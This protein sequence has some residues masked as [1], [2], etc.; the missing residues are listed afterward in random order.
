M[1]IG[2]LR[3]SDAPSEIVN[4]VVVVDDVHRRSI[5]LESLGDDCLILSNL[6]EGLE[7]FERHHY[8]ITIIDSRS[9]A[10]TDSLQAIKKSGMI[11]DGF[12][13][14]VLI[15]RWLLLSLLEVLESMSVFS[16]LSI[17]TFDAKTNQAR[18]SIRRRATD[19]Y[20]L[21]AF[22]SGYRAALH[23][24]DVPGGVPAPPA[25]EDI[26]LKKKYLSLLEAVAANDGVPRESATQSSTFAAKTS[27]S[28]EVD[29]L[30][31]SLKQAIADKDSLER[32]YES[33]STSSLGKVTLKYWQWRRGGKKVD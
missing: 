26:D 16:E 22:L 11:D 2:R 3:S 31:R 9:D 30:K 8:S 12:T 20:P 27:S 14:N 15:P 21:G 24:E 5:G 18:I 32:K 19:D 6:D 33:L 13:A 25:K 4:S 1:Y 7:F 29:V 17:S 10:I 23:E 28:G